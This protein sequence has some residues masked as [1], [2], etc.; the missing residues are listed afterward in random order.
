MT[1]V[2]LPCAG[3]VF[4]LRRVTLTDGSE[5]LL[6][7]L[8]RD[9]EDGCDASRSHGNL[10]LASSF[11]STL[12]QSQH[13][14]GEVRNSAVQYI[15]FSRET[16]T[17]CVCVCVRLSVCVCVRE[18]VSVHACVCG[19]AFACLYSSACVLLFVCRVSS[20]YTNCKKNNKIYVTVRSVPFFLRTWLLNAW[21]RTASWCSYCRSKPTPNPSWKTLM[22]RNPKRTTSPPPE[23]RQE[24]KKMPTMRR[25]P[26]PALGST[27][28]TTRP[29][30]PSAKAHSASSSWG[31]VGRMGRRWW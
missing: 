12:D 4:Q 27:A 25:C 16:E 13:S 26:S 15:Y 9:P 10:T 22:K 24:R 20:D 28:P 5:M 19:C 1:R 11:N 23:C 18:R 14:L 31:G 17:L 3:V 30:P 7:W 6:L 21:I 8:S 2:P 29:C